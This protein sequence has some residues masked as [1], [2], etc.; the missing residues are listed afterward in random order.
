MRLNKISLKLLIIFFLASSISGCDV[1]VP[2]SLFNRNDKLPVQKTIA[3]I[4]KQEI[5][6]EEV[7]SEEKNYTRENGT[8][9]VF[10]QGTLEEVSE[11]Y[12]LPGQTKNIMGVIELEKDKTVNSQAMFSTLDDTVVS[13]DN[14]GTLTGINFGVSSIKVSWKRGTN[15]HKYIKVFVLKEIPLLENNELEVSE[16]EPLP[17]AL[18]LLDQPNDVVPLSDLKQSSVSPAPEFLPIRG[19]VYFKDTPVWGVDVNIQVESLKNSETL[20]YST[21]TKNG[22][23][24]FDNIPYPSN[25][26]IKTSFQ[27]FKPSVLKKATMKYASQNFFRIDIEKEEY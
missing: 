16:P 2:M 26:E 13:V 15:L 19:R 17:T 20:K 5:V 3:P 12:L 22:Y 11:V 6:R 14:N 24:T 27:G 10:Y 4:K 18:P 8:M 7:K 21:Q 9:T 23:F 25:F 1:K